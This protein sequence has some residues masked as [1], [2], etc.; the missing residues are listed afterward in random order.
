MNIE[1]AT[2]YDIPK[3]YALQR[4]SFESE[5]AMIGSRDVP[6]LQETKDEYEKDF[7][8]WIT[9]KLVDDSQEVIGAIDNTD[10]ILD[11]MDNSDKIIDD[12]DNSDK[13]IGAIRYRLVGDI[14]EVGRLMVHP[15][16]RQQGLA[17]RMLAEIDML[18]PKGTKELYTSTKSFINIRLYNKMGYKSVKEVDGGNGLSF[19]YM[20]K[21]G[22]EG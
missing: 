14:V 6:A 4:L 5:A 20:R 10:K 17:Q 16:Y 19:V 12:M 11:A 2:A 13:I 8:N 3:L 22:M 9:L 1:R 7:A 15:E 18:C 21:N